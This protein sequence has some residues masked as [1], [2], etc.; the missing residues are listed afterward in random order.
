MRQF[1]GGEGFWGPE[2]TVTSAVRGGN[3]RVGRAL[4][5]S[6]PAYFKSLGPWHLLG[7]VGVIIPVWQTGDCS[8]RH[9]V[10]WQ[11]DSNQGLQPHESFGTESSRGSKFAS[12][13]KWASQVIKRRVVFVFPACFDI[14]G[15]PAGL[16]GCR[17]PWRWAEVESFFVGAL[18][19]QI[20]PAVT[21]NAQCGVRS[22]L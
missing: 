8:S 1:N 16:I 22:P 11:R 10:R 12:A 21:W 18:S 6:H 13:E 7:E 4:L 17:L 19:V 15:H 2:S 14:Y 3:Q 20:P 5:C 9:V